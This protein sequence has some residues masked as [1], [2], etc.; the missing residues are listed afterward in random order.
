VR[1]G[2]ASFSFAGRERSRDRTWDR[3]LLE[4]GVWL[5]RTPAFQELRGWDENIVL[6]A[7]AAG[8]RKV[9]L[10]TI[11]DRNGWET[12]EVFRFVREK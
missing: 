12:F 10:Q 9:L 5:G 8:Y 7:A 11:P 1:Y 2:S 3:V 6:A 4:H